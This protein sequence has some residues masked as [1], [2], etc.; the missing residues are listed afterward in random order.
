VEVRFLR[1]RM[2]SNHPQPR[3]KEIALVPIVLDEGKAER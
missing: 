3:N 1:Q 2:A